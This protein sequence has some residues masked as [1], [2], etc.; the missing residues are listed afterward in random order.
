[1]SY[2]HCILLTAYFDLKLVNI[3]HQAMVYAASIR[4]DLECLFDILFNVFPSPV[5][6]LDII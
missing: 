6:V 3:L 2:N 4:T 1:M 5:Y